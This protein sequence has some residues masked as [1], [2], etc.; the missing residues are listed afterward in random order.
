METDAT[1]N[2]DRTEKQFFSLLNDLSLLDSISFGHTKYFK[3]QCEK[4]KKQIKLKLNDLI[5]ELR[6]TGTNHPEIQ[7]YF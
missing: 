6:K 3:E 7:R 1:E 4:K 2:V 5:I